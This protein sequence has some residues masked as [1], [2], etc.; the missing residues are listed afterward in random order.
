GGCVISM[1]EM[2]KPV[3][4]NGVVTWRTKK[5]PM[6][7]QRHSNSSSRLDEIWDG[8][9]SGLHGERYVESEKIS[10]AGRKSRWS[11]AAQT[12]SIDRRTNRPTPTRRGSALRG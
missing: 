1:D 9:R 7:L 2:P 4:P 10:Q 6:S 5:P 3:R 11:H 8:S 12:R